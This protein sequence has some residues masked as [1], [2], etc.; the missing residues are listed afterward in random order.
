M[1]FFYQMSVLKAFLAKTRHFVEESVDQRCL[2]NPIIL[3]RQGCTPASFQQWREGRQLAG[4]GAEG[5]FFT[6]PCF[7]WKAFQE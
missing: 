6:A 7:H 2:H 3:F 4:S 1:D 5:P